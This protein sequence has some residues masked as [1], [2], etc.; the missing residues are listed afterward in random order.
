MKKKTNAEL[1]VEIAKD[2]LKHIETEKIVAKIKWVY[3]DPC[4]RNKYKGKQLQEILSKL[5]KCK[6]CALGGMFYS[7]VDRHNKFKLTGEGGL[8]SVNENPRAMRDSMSMFTEKQLFLIECAFESRDV[9]HGCY[10]SGVSDAVIEKAKSYIRRH[11][12]GINSDGN[13]ALIHIMKNIIRNKG[14]FRP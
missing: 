14:T 12:T 6:V 13:D 2:V 9:D 4:S 3:F 5:K 8:Q 11:I 1:R 10:K 7:Y